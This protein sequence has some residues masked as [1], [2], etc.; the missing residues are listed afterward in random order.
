M[1][2]RI[3]KKHFL[4][5]VKGLNRKS[6]WGAVFL[7][8][9]FASYSYAQQTITGK[10]T[11]ASDGSDLPGV[12]IVVKGTVSGTQT[13][14]EGHY[15]LAGVPADGVLVFSFIGKKTL[16]IPVGNRSVVDVTLDD[17]YATL[18][19]IVVVGYGM[20]KKSD[21]TGSITAVSSRDFV[22]GNI[23]NPE[24]LV[25]GKIAGVQIA[26]DGGQPGSSGRIRIRG[27]SSLNASNDPLI[28]IDGVPLDNSELSG[29]SNPLSFVNPN[30]IETF[31]VLKDASATAIYGSRASNG[32]ILITTK[33]GRAGDGLRVDFSTL[34]SSSQRTGAVDVLTADEFR[35]VVSSTGTAAQRALPGTAN[36]NWQDEIYR[37]AFSTD[38]NL[39]V[40]GALKGMPFRV[41]VGY[42]NQNGVL[43]TS[44]MGR[45]SG[46]IGISPKLLKEH[47]KVDIN[48]KGTLIKNRFAD[49]GAIGAAAFFDP[50]QPVYSDSPAYGGYFEWLTDGKPNT[51]ATRNPLAMLELR[52]DRSTVQRSIG[53]IQLDYTVHGLP[54]LRANLNLGYDV[55]SSSG[56]RSVPA[57]AAVVFY[58]DGQ[59]FT[60]EQDR[61]NKTLEFYLNYVKELGAIDSKFDIM[62]GY[63]WQD[64]MRS[65]F[66][67][68]EPVA[69]DTVLSNIPYKTQNTLVSFYGRLNYGLKDR[70]L[71]TATLR[72][73][74]SSRFSPENRWGLFPS[75]A[76]AWKLKEE[77]FLKSAKGITDLKLR[78]GYG[79]T[80]QQDVLNDYPY[81]ARYTLSQNTAMYQFGD[82]FV[83]TFRPEAYDANIRWE[84][85]QTWNAGLD[86]AFWDG[87][88]SGAIDFYQRQ[89]KDLLSTIPV[90]AG[91]NLTNQLLTNV[92]KIENKGVEWT[93]NVSP[94]RKERWNLDIGF[95]LTYNE[96]KIT[97]LTKVPDLTFEGIQVG[98][99]SGGVG[100]NAQIHSVGYPTHTF[101]MY[102]Q[103]YQQNGQ[104]VEGVYAD[105]N[106]SGSVTGE[107][108]YRYQSPAPR[109]FFGFS[110]QFTYDRLSAGLVVRGNIGNYVYN[111]VSSA[112]GAYNN[113]NNPN[114]YLSN[115]HRSVL[116][117]QF[118]N[119]Q[120]TSDFYVENASFLRMDNINV[121][122]DFG[123]VLHEKAR[124]RLSANIQNVFVI[125]KYSGL[126]PEIP[127]GIDNNFYPRPRIYAIGLNLGF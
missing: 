4:E 37:N 22:Q 85:T 89:T 101:Y 69:R 125:T 9:V 109:L 105:R 110:P 49:Q 113:I 32:V 34:F 55:S 122:Y 38:N 117:T 52:D 44:G 11:D 106:N 82:Q 24:Q 40:T 50:T 73:D 19:E 25:A 74:G 67:K 39:S 95:N 118:V 76:L 21:L 77:L 51:L 48:V 84:Q 68:D 87:R 124:L 23:V 102:K 115:V 126:D 127:N 35:D 92:G 5:S 98:G 71:L 6:L 10:V 93:V 8:M 53:N 26:S 45:T 86:Y 58:R 15:T 100:N 42:L 91:S 99:I 43:K 88:I 116:T 65:G 30:D 54:D 75:V 60:Y 14:T 28:V 61:N 18:H 2:E 36:T 59:H 62:A 20:Q 27:G 57:E 72:R 104:P 121:G 80:G 46:A 81:L 31:T 13:N 111:N 78:L 56:E 33:K 70:Y 79:V 63:S 1:L 29:A 41:S 97:N 103:V 16:E 47:L 94:F 112:A 123:S 119:S 66:D 107:D 83:Y 12:N 108:M 114:N 7:G 17:D 90:P 96:N 64:F 120:Y 3:Y